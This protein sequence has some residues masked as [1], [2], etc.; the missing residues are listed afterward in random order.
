MY[1]RS[2]IRYHHLSS[3]SINRFRKYPPITTLEENDVYCEFLKNI[4]NE[5]YV[6]PYSLLQSLANRSFSA[7]VIPALSLGLSLS[8]PY[9]APERL[10]SFIRRMLIS[11][12]SRRVLVEHHRGF[13]IFPSLFSLP[14][15]YRG[16]QCSIDGY[17]AS[18]SV[19]ETVIQLW[20]S[21]RY[22]HRKSCGY[23]LYGAQCSELCGEMCWSVERSGK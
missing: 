16:H 9:L 23:H 1:T 8:S 11:R 19:I 5:Q 4:L 17:L 20:E 10:D 13:P 7:T 6:S 15:T 12:I 22:R 21:C 2:S 14:F 3:F 18:R